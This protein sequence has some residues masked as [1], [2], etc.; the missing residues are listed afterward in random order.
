MLWLYLHFPQL[1]LDG[2]LAQD[3]LMPPTIIV[4]SKKHVV[5]QLNDAARQLGINIGMGLGTAAAMNTSLSVYEF[6]ERNEQQRIQELAQC[7]YLDTAE[8]HISAPNGLLL[9]V[10]NMLPLHPNLAHYWKV[11]QT[12]LMSQ[13]V[14]YHFGLG[15]SP[16]AA[17]LLAQAAF[18]K[19][20]EDKATL[21]AEVGKLPI[22]SLAFSERRKQQLQRV[23]VKTVQ[24]LLDIPLVELGKR[25]DTELVHYVGRLQ[26]K[27]HH[28][29]EF[30]QPPQ[31][32]QR[33]ITLLFELEN[34]SYLTKPLYK[35]LQQLEE[36]LK[37]RDKLT[38]EIALT[39]VQRDTEAI[40]LKVGS[41]QGE[42]RA[43]KWQDLC[44]LVL[45][46]TQLSAPLQAITL[47]VDKFCEPSNH[48]D[49]LFSEPIGT[50]SRADLLSVLR[51]KL[52]EGAI[53]G[54]QTMP[55]ARPEY[56]TNHCEPRL[57]CSKPSV[58]E[59]SAPLLRPNFLLAQIQP[60]HNKV[61]LLQGPERISTGWWDGHE[62][63]RDYFIAQDEQFRRLWIFK[64]RQQRWFIHGIFS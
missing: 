14:Y 21:S 48:N 59:K 2:L 62:I 6:K 56:A 3:A 17:Q 63:E 31:I 41:S 42:Y 35:L 25:F 49:D 37:S 13:Q 15:Y 39:L 64:D 47:R 60:L 28:P 12:R 44:H 61:M 43:Q 4:S 18:D 24:S 10:S 33:D 50:M 34:L 20:D 1:Q 30:Y 51:A 38:H 9:K 16:L 57:Q 5:V 29:V 8:I 45:E 32:F 54:I 46:R 27:L 55:D 58:T 11:I 19:I 7:L 36:F 52:G 26:G 40:V 23:G 53:H 22:G